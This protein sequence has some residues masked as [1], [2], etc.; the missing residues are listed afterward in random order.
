MW[1][2][3]GPKQQLRDA[4]HNFA[5]DKATSVAVCQ[6]IQSERETATKARGLDPRFDAQ[7]KEKDIHTKLRGN[8][9]EEAQATQSHPCKE[10]TGVRRVQAG[11]HR[12][13][14][15]MQAYAQARW[16]EQERSE[17]GCN[18]LFYVSQSTRSCSFWR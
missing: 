6:A 15:S 16:R 5:V 8:T 2:E 9:S 1:H 14:A 13:A 12:R 3:T 11:T 17:T 18:V 7:D 10:G 4:S